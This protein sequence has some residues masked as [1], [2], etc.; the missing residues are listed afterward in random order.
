MRKRILRSVSILLTCALL[1]AI[2]TCAPF[3][4]SAAEVDSADAVATVSADVFDSF[5]ELSDGRYTLTDQT[6]ALTKNFAAEGYLYIPSDVTAVIDLNGHT[7]D[8]GLTASSATGHVIRNE[9][10]LTIRDSSG[11]NTG[12]I[13]GGYTENGGAVNN[14]GTLNIEG[15]TITNNRAEENGGG[16]YNAGTL[17]L[18]GGRI[19][20]NASDGSGSGV[21][22]CADGTLNMSGSPVVKDN[23]KGNLYLQG[24]SVINVTG[25]FTST[26]QV[27]V[28]AKIMPRA[29]T[30]GFNNGNLSAITF[31]NGHTAAKLDDNGEVVPNTATAT[32]G[33]W[34]ELKTVVENA[35]SN[36]VNVALS[37]NITNNGSKRDRIQAKDNANVTIDLCGHTVDTNRTSDNGGV[38][39]YFFL[40]ASGTSNV[41]VKDSFGSGTVK[42]GNGEKGGAFYVSPSATLN[43]YNVAINN[44]KVS[45]AGGAVYN[46]GKLNI[47]G[48]VFA[49][50]T[51]NSVG[52]AIYVQEEAKSLQI[53]CTRICENTA[54]NGGA[55]YQNANDNNITSVITGCFID[56]NTA[57][58]SG[59]AIYLKT[60]E[61]SMTGCS[62]IGNTAA[63]SGGA[64]YNLSAMSMTDCVVGN[65]KVTDGVGG[66][67][68]HYASGKTATLTNTVLSGSSAGYGGGVY[69]K[70]GKLSVS[71]GKITGNTATSGTGG[72]IRSFE[73]GSVTLSG[74]TVSNNT[75]ADVGGGLY[76]TNGGSTSVD[77]CTFIGNS[78]NRG[79]GIYISENTSMTVSDSTVTGNRAT[80]NSAGIYV[81]DSSDTKLYLSGAVNISGNLLEENGTDVES[82]LYL[83]GGKVIGVS[84]GLAETSTIGVT[85]E[86][87]DRN[88]TDGLNAANDAVLARFTLDRETSDDW[89]LS[90]SLNGSE[91][92]VK[93]IDKISVSSWTE[94]QSAIDNGNY[95]KYITLTQDCDANGKTR[96][97]IYDGKVITI[98]LNGKTL[99][100]GLESSDSDGHVIEVHNGGVLTVRDSGTEGK[101]KGGWAT[102]GGGVN[103]NGG[104]TFTLEGGSILN[105]KAEDGGGVYIHDGASFTMTGGSIKSNEASD[106]GGGIYA[107][108]TMV[109]QQGA[110][111]IGNKAKWG[112]GVYID[113]DRSGPTFSATHATISENT[114]TSKGGGVYIWHGT[115]TMDDCLMKNN[116][117]YDGGAVVNT[118]KCTFNATNTTFEKNKSTNQG[119]GAIV[120]EYTVSVTGCTFKENSAEKSGGALYNDGVANVTD[121]TFTGNKSLHGSGGAIGQ[122]KGTLNL[123]DGSMSQ[124][125]AG[126]Y[127]GAVYVDEET[128]AVNIQGDV[129]IPE[130]TGS[131]FYLGTGKKLTL[132]APLSEDAVI[133]VHLRSI[134]GVFTTNFSSMHPEDDPADYFIPDDSY[135][136]I[137][138]ENGEAMVIESDWTLLRNQV[139]SASSGTVITLEKDWRA[140]DKDKTITIPEGKTLTIDLNGHTIDGDKKIGSVFEIGGTLILTDSSE[141]GKGIVKGGSA[142]AIDN[143]GVLRLTGGSISAS[144]GTLG[145][146]V[147]CLGTEEKPVV[148]VMSGG[149]ITDSEGVKGG[150]VYVNEYSTATITGG[151][152]SGNSATENGGAFFVKGVVNLSGSTVISENFSKGSGGAFYLE[153]GTLNYTGGTI[154][155]NSASADAGAIYVGTAPGAALNISNLPVI[156]DNSA[157][158]GNNIL[159]SLG[160]KINVTGILHSGAKVDVVT[161]DPSNALTKNYGANGNSGKG[162]FTY[163]GSQTSLLEKNGEL[164]FA[165]PE[166]DYVVSTWKELQETLRDAEDNAVIVVRSD[167]DATAEG[168][169]LGYLGLNSGRTV[170]VDLNGHELNRHR[171]SK[172]KDGH[173]FWIRGGSHLII[174]D[175]AGSGI[176]TG[177]Y[178]N[179]GGAININTGSTVTING[180]SVRDNRADEDGGGIYVYGTLIMNGGSVCFNKADND[181]GGIKLDDSAIMHLDNALISRNTANNDGGG[182]SI[183]LENNDST[184]SNSVISYNTADDNGGGFEMDEDDRTLTIENTNIDHNISGD[185]GGGF[186]LDLGKVVL[187][188]ST[189]SYNS[190]DAG[191][192]VCLAAGTG[193]DNVSLTA[194]RTE[195]CHNKANKGN[196]GG[197]HCGNNPDK[198]VEFFGC[199]INNNTSKGKGGGVYFSSKGKITFQNDPDNTAPATEPTTEP[200]TEP[201][202]DP[203]GDVQPTTADPDPEDL[204]PYDL[205]GFGEISDN[206]A[207]DSGGGFYCYSGNYDKKNP[208]IIKSIVFANNRSYDGEGGGAI[209]RKGEQ[210]NGCI[211]EV[212]N[213]VFDS[214]RCDKKGFYHGGAIHNDGNTLIINGGWFRNNYTNGKGGALYLYA[215]RDSNEK[216]PTDL[217]INPYNGALPVFT[218]NN[219][220]LLGGSLYI[221]DD[222]NAT[223]N[224]MKVVHDQ[225]Q[226]AAVYCNE[227]IDVKGKIIVRNNKAK[228]LYFC[229][230]DDRFNLIG[231][232]DPESDIG[233]AVK[234]KY[235]EVTDDYEEFHGDEDPSH[236]FFASEEN[237]GVGLNEDGEVEIRS[238]DWIELQRKLDAPGASVVTLDKD[239]KADN[240]DVPLNIAQGKSLILDLNGHTLSGG[241]V[242]RVLNNNGTLTIRD[243]SELKLG[244]I[245]EGN[246][247]HGGGIKNNGTLTI[248]GI[249]F[250]ENK[251]SQGGAIYNNT[252]ATL[253]VTGGTFRGNESTE[254]GAAIANLGAAVISGGTI[255][256]NASRGAA[257]AVYNAGTLTVGSAEIKDNAAATEGGA[258]VVAEGSTFTVTQKP[259]IKDNDA[260]S[261]KNILLYRGTAVTIG[262]GFLSGAT[263]DMATRDISHALT[264]DFDLRS[265][266]VSSF[267]YNES[268]TISLVHRDGELYFPDVS[269]D[270]PVDSWQGLQNAINDPENAGKVIGLTAD[271]DGTGKSRLSLD[272]KA[273]TIE[274]AGHA[275]DRKRTS[276]TGSGNVFYVYGGSAHLT[277]RDAVETG[278][279]TGGYTSDDGGGIY[280][281]GNGKVTIAGGSVQ[282]NKAEYDG[283]GVFIDN[284]TLTMT[285]GAISGNYANETAGAVFC[286]SSGT[287]NLRNAT[288]SGN[289]SKNEGGALNLHLEDSNSVIENCVITRNLTKEEHGGAIVLKASGKTLNLTNTTISKNTADDEGGGV[290]IHSGTLVMTGGSIEENRAGDGGGVYVSSNTEFE[291]KS[292]AKVSGN[293][294]VEDG[295][296]G[297]TCYGRLTVNGS[298]ISGNKAKANGGGLYYNNSDVNADLTNAAILENYTESN[299]GG[300]Y[301]Q[302]GEITVSGGQISRNMSVD[303]G[304]VYV[305]DDTDF[306]A[307]DSAVFDH[308]QA[309][310]KSGGAIFNMGHTYVENVTFTGNE[311]KVN[312]GGI[313]SDEDMNVKDCTFTENQSL[314]GNGGALYQY[315]EKLTLKG[316]NTI[317]YNNA[318]IYGAGVY[319]D[320]DA[321][322]N[323]QDK[324]NITENYGPNLYLHEDIKIKFSGS[325]QNGAKIG[326]SMENDTGVFTEGFSELANS[327]PEAYFLSDDGYEVYKE[328]REGALRFELEEDNGFISRND[329]IR[330]PEKVTGKNWMSAISGE[331]YINEINM[332]RTHDAAMYQVEG[333]IDSSMIKVYADYYGAPISFGLFLACFMVGAGIVAAG[334]AGI[335]LVPYILGAGVAFL[336]L[337]SISMLIGY[338]VDFKSK[339]NAQTQLRYIDEQMEDGVRIFDLRINNRNYEELDSDDHFDDNKNLWHCHGKDA[340]AGTYFA[341]NHE[342]DVLSANQT[343]EWAAEFLEKHPTEVI[344]FEYGVESTTE[345]GDSEVVNGRLKRILKEFSYRVN[346]AT[347]KTFLYMEDGVFGKEYAI[348]KLKDCR[349][350]ILYR[351][352]RQDLTGGFSW[353]STYGTSLQSLVGTPKER[354]E[355]VTQGFIERPSPYVLTDA[356]VHRDFNSGFFLNT[357]DEPMKLLFC[358]KPLDLESDILWGYNE[359]KDWEDKLGDKILFSSAI[360][361]DVVGLFVEGG[362]FNQQG[363]YV[364][365]VSPD[366]VTQRE[367]RIVWYSNFYDEIQY[368]TITVKSGLPGDDTVKTYRVLKGTKITIPNSIYDN[369]SELG[370]F[371]NWR[372]TTESNGSWEPDYA[373]PSKDE[374][375]DR[376][377][378]NDKYETNYDYLMA[379]SYVEEQGTAI[380]LDPNSAGDFEPGDVIRI[381]DDTTFVAQWGEQPKAPVKVV[382]NDGNDGDGLR[383]KLTLNVNAIVHGGT[384]DAE[385]HAY[386]DS[387]WQT[388]ANGEINTITPVWDQVKV[389]QAYPNG[390]END[391]YRYEVSG[392]MNDGFTVT[393]I[394]NPQKQVTVAGTVSWSDNHD[395]FGKRPD[396]VTLRL[397]K[398]DVSTEQT[399]TASAANNW[400]FSFGAYNEYEADGEGGYRHVTYSVIEEPF[401]N[402][403]A[404]AGDGFDITNYFVSNDVN[405]VNGVVEW[406]DS[407]NGYGTRPD[408]V[409]VTLYAKAE[410]EDDFTE[411]G[412]QTIFS[413]K[414]GVSDVFSFDVEQYAEAHVG[415]EITYTLWQNENPGYTTE[416]T[417]DEKTG[418][419]YLRNTL[420]M[421]DKL[422]KGHSVTLNGDIKLNYF[423]KLTPEQA[424]SAKVSFRWYNKQINN[425]PLTKVGEDMYKASC[426]VAAAEMTYDVSATLSIGG[427]TVETNSYS[428]AKYAS[429]LLIDADYYDKFMQDHASLGKD[430]A[431]NEY[432]KLIMLLLSM[433]EYG[434]SAQLYFDR[435]TSLLANGGYH[436]FEDLEVKPESINPIPQD[437]HEGLEEYGLRYDGSTL[438][439]IGGTTLR[440]VYTVTDQTKF[441]AVKNSITID[442]EPVAPVQYSST[443]VSFEKTN[444]V[445]SKLDH[446]YTLQIG[447]SAYRYSALHYCRRVMEKS[448]NSKMQELARMTYIYNQA[449]N[450]YF[451]D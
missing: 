59:G 89:A 319:I 10:T 304:G 54:V 3:S 374:L 408:S 438:V 444:I 421:S 84:N 64:V 208:V 329:N 316:V 447:D 87:Y 192:G 255:S 278:I 359:D 395:A 154:S 220:N 434:S 298:F 125:T 262:E 162:V 32:A 286:S 43:L 267:S 306:T 178:A 360:D 383:E 72:G 169:D 231:K 229:D 31:A 101:I 63:A 246:G 148:F 391:G 212:T 261:G 230:D 273:A 14:T 91:F 285:G 113:D 257:G 415:E 5:G 33:S 248:D 256:E 57:S 293:A 108:Y 320:P 118:D 155:D 189:V 355:Q 356:L 368:R 58:T 157:S 313:W 112:G 199:K 291:M 325:L 76:I 147:N 354:I 109:L 345:G 214:N 168:S 310:V 433:E 51:A 251:A 187:T 353:G 365:R 238:T 117:A 440:H 235:D 151:T 115:F 144:S 240:H 38:F 243:S 176:I 270:V 74:C 392:N 350:Q 104:A 419:F 351:S 69:V 222:C 36:P 150:A 136:V 294:A 25:A 200:A 172:D 424:Q 323:L 324:P 138:D 103:L 308:N 389:S 388:V 272:N 177:G 106:E 396:T 128:S 193:D 448:S 332:M 358:R 111:V 217:T 90:K 418:I 143:R 226:A 81:K 171:T 40:W 183:E 191:G 439:Y 24:S 428:V 165:E 239:Y 232:L 94:L 398:D 161:R 29:V 37:A 337:S 416:L 327:N 52:G 13:T 259:Y 369:E 11:S 435:N 50:N 133:R 221:D 376:V 53:S 166:G 377:D 77:G 373:L 328:G 336:V 27:D 45:D 86:R 343:L 288:I 145:G 317:Q 250:E 303:G 156:E 340:K 381:M 301:L 284:G 114:A 393:M 203:S 385:Y 436:L 382:W 307:I 401:K 407:T 425:A 346:P 141:D 9:G 207:G 399:V 215:V 88:L 198:D 17:N 16:I 196:G 402:Y 249:L 335:G 175:T 247:T 186:F 290:Y 188:D 170:T 451:N 152:I 42:G 185:D 271:L 100:R 344:I 96:I 296:G 41:T 98:D 197:I 318:A 339:L 66:A 228:D 173:V 237:C 274:L 164:W 146:A 167:L 6:Y 241:D 124:N 400:Q 405:E 135:S 302:A 423:L 426:P 97:R 333:N 386:A 174:N 210:N 61:I 432:N 384:A 55:I 387:E 119:G 204:C 129:H 85:A 349:G 225:N 7:I 446:E 211:M 390:N 184:I 126:Y 107:D 276:D 375:G 95:E 277:I 280:I 442:G 121:C 370:T 236:Y 242:I 315:D 321:K 397:Y 190:G 357:T 348:P 341:L 12:K 19:I 160:K 287:V 39:E 163:N 149:S 65:S 102:R 82:N 195:F 122:H 427:E 34:D 429:T 342:G 2:I 331:R 130:H 422:F 245:T 445:A 437:M 201:A 264:Q 209:Y 70:E 352:D 312:G 309:I 372:A 253:T 443:Q 35:D 67:I 26:A 99:N 417:Q 223:I 137:P 30:S 281:G 205:T 110:Y 139:E 403:S 297:I 283:G 224:G 234:D 44:N 15:G 92:Y 279:I 83:A 18:T 269:Y 79:G 159:L 363:K 182:L 179:N 367:A 131:T 330:D 361:K 233:V 202:T 46:R 23:V 158:T 71:G 28:S 75:S 371:L 49:E 366:G 206:Y 322:I 244:T 8:R 218:H 123:S 21:Y 68:Y 120:N 260:P 364:G 254:Y 406:K 441:D 134:S 378:A 311:A 127:G 292:G 404:M 73:G 1:F 338:L 295:G 411:L 420:D 300:I 414:T 47:E 263:V 268:S 379:H 153:S 430:G 266:S 93:K 62:L 347:G 181:G 412:K 299:G 132:A 194:T 48:C 326:V 116:A 334:T 289:R 305:T 78:A 216:R 258:I 413:N 275:I 227:D 380:E 394:H 362:N 431:N 140:I 449:A 450:D 219:A 4:T 180:G 80:V 252:G 56:G 60:G 265:A 282:G 314:T 409:T 142:A 410:G 213:C 105:N 20:G 22:N